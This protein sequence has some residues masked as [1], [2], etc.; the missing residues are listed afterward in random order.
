MF[1]FLMS[2]D[3]R[4]EYRKRTYRYR[5]EFIYRTPTPHDWLFPYTGTESDFVSL[6]GRLTLAPMFVFLC[7]CFIHL[8]SSE[9]EARV[10][11]LVCF[12]VMDL[13]V[14]A[15]Y[16]QKVIKKKKRMEREAQD[17]GGASEKEDSVSC[18]D[19]YEDDL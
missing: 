4:E 1:L 10:T 18:L 15:G 13:F 11:L 3:K 7:I 16:I 14:L 8:M 19:L 12:A 17:T 9:Y 2:K 6:F 5:K